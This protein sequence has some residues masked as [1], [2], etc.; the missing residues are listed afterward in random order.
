[1]FDTS[2]RET[3]MSSNLLNEYEAAKR[4]GIAVA[5]IRSW[6]CNGRVDLPWVKMSKSVRYRDEDIE[7]FISSSTTGRIDQ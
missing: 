3:I 6:R 4:L 7:N 5:T 1:M 2:S